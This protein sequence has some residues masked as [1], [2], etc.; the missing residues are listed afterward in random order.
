M[1]YP[2]LFPASGKLDSEKL[3]SLTVT[4]LSTLDNGPYPGSWAGYTFA[5]T[6]NMTKVV[7]NHTV[8]WGIT[9]ERSGQD[10]HIQLTTAAAPATANQNGAFRFFDTGHPQATGLAMANVLL[11][12][13]ND[14]SEFSDKPLTPFVATMFDG[15]VQDSWKPTASLTLDAGVRY[16]LWEP[17]YSKWNTLSMFDPRFYDPSRAAV[18]DRTGGFV[19]SGDRYNGVVLPGDEPLPSGLSRFPYLSDY[20]ERYH[21]L[22]RGFAQ[23]HK[24]GFQPRLGLAYTDQSEDDRS[25]RR[26]EVLQPHRHQPGLG[27]GRPA[28]VRGAVHRHQWQCRRAQR[29]RA[30][31][32]SLHHHQS[33]PGAEAS[34]GVDRKRD[35]AAGAARGALTGSVLRRPAWLQ[36]PA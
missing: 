4:G 28:A 12:N 25:R 23:T 20:S 9:V 32:L 33:G 22:P 1:N 2:F 30:A 31:G 14:Y 15:F 6:N 34:D 21:G 26:R 19:V 24:A 16:S 18:I 10:D 3:P 29:C 13:F 7:D 11:G 5:V 35:R 36:Q 8:K 27:P 17:W